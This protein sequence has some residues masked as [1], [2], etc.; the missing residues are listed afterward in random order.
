MGPHHRTA[1]WHG[2][3]PRGFAFPLILSF[4]KGRVN[5]GNSEEL[6]QALWKRATGYEVEERESI[7]DK[8][9]KL[10][11]IKV[12]KRHVPPDIEAI[13]QVRRL[14]TLGEWE[15]WEEVMRGKAD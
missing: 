4:I 11:H 14:I 5:M 1:L 7:I 2:R 15:V 8:D 13:A 6:K 3:F 9:G 12:K 10:K